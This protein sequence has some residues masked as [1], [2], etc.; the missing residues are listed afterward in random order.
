MFQ[1]ENIDYAI[2]LALIELPHWH[3]LINDV[4]HLFI[5]F[6]DYL[7][8]F[9]PSS[10]IILGVLHIQKCA[11]NYVPEA[12]L[13]TVNLPTRLFYV[14]FG[15]AWLCGSLLFFFLLVLEIFADLP[16]IPNCDLMDVFDTFILGLLMMQLLMM[17]L[18]NFFFFIILQ[19][20]PL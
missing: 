20:N 3:V 11:I 1:C 19:I 10:L 2:R 4:L 16:L 12:R 15:G 8:L 13:R 17:M 18:Q 7:L 9:R 14:T 6:F 5:P